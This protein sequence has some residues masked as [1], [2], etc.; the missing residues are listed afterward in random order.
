MATIAEQEF[1]QNIAVLKDTG[2]MQ[3]GYLTE[4]QIEEVFPAMTQ[5]QKKL[6]LDY[7]KENK[8]GIGEAMPD[9][10]IL[11]TE[12]HSH[13]DLYLDELKALEEIDDSMRRVLIMNAL[14]GDKDARERLMKAYLR[15]VVDIA[16]LYT[17]QGVELFDLIGEGNVAVTMAISMLESIEK[18]E[19]CDEMVSRSVMNAMEEA[20]GQ[21]NDEI[22]ALQRMV[23]AVGKVLKKAK[24][25]SDALRR[26]V[27]IEELCAESE[28]TEEEIRDAIRFSSDLREYIS[29][30]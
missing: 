22:E 17:G 20:I 15:T 16:K 6:L 10:E 18:P 23:E 14:N 8:I 28:L 27:T 12:D 3:G 7:F 24:P 5:E 2:I 4:E 1:I 9:A 30:D 26:K 19:D 29:E 11:S 25:L 21:E 13:L